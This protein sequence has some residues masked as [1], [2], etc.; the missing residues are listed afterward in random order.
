MSEDEAPENLLGSYLRDWRTRLDPA[1]PADA[2]KIRAQ[3]GSTSIR[4]DT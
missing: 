2:E 1:T 3:I 4:E